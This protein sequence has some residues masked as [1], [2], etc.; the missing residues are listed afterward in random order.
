MEATIVFLVTL[1]LL[2]TRAERKHIPWIVGFALVI[3][4]GNFLIF[5]KFLYVD[6]PMTEWLWG[7]V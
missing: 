4:L 3:A 1:C 5:T 2:F 6:L 7:G